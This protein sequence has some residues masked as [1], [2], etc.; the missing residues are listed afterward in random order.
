MENKLYLVNLKCSESYQSSDKRVIPSINRPI[1]VTISSAT[2]M[3]S[4]LRTAPII[5]LSR[6]DYYY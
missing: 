2:P 5:H 4:F 6:K 1:R 3:T